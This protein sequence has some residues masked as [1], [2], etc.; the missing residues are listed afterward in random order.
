[1]P[2]DNNNNS[3]ASFSA[4]KKHEHFYLA[5]MELN[6]MLCLLNIESSIDSFSLV[7]DQNLCYYFNTL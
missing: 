2:A 5:Y 1:M 4:Y 6:V 3:L 7:K